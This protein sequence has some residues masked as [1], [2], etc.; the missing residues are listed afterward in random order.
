[1]LE[2]NSHFLLYFKKVVSFAVLRQ[3]KG[4]NDTRGHVFLWA[5][6]MNYF[7]S[8]ESYRCLT[9]S[10]ACRQQGNMLLWCYEHTYV[11]WNHFCGVPAPNLLSTIISGFHNLENKHLKKAT[12]YMVHRGTRD[13]LEWGSKASWLVVGGFGWNIFSV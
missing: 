13:W 6:L 9:R 3:V 4:E 5:M 7:P 12:F 2:E 1:M 8:G 10:C 11:L